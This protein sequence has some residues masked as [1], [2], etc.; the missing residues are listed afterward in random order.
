MEDA[1]R[2]LTIDGW[3]LFSILRYSYQP[4]TTFGRSSVANLVDIYVIRHDHYKGGTIW[5]SDAPPVALDNKCKTCLE[6]IDD[7]TL[8]KLICYAKAIR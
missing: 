7:I 5:K 1:D 8:K 2:I 6:T 4:S 3:T